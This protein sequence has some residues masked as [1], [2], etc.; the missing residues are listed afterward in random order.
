MSENQKKFRMGIIGAGIFAEANHYPSLSLHFFDGVERAAVCDL[1]KERADRIAEKYGW[2][3]TYDDLKKM[4]ES[5]Y[6]DGVI[7]C[8]GAKAS[9]DVTTQVLENGLPVFLEKPSSIDLEGTLKIAEVAKRKNLIVQVGH[10][11]RHG[12]A[13]RRAMEIVKDREK[14]GNIIQIESK[15]HGFPI[16]PT[17]YT[18]MLEWQCHNLDIVR[19]FAGDIKEI[20]AKSFKT[21]KKTGALTAMVRFDSGALGIFG[22]GTYG[23]PGQFSE[24]IEILGDKGR[25]VIITNA[26]EVTFYDEDVGEVWTSDWNPISKNQSHVFNG[27]VGELL[28][29]FE[30]VKNG[31]QPEPSIHDEVKTMSYLIEIAN[32]ADI[33]I[34]W[35]FISSAL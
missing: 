6:I 24:R 7:V 1:D 18:C 23:G 30:C 35:G 17:F 34:E 11:K 4:V 28:H 32:K 16:F 33:P 19:A 20:E 12:L 29:F 3:K 5:E 27:Y 14:F 10:Q 22:W 25:G 13:Y 26:R 21:G 8:V 9:V 2:K 31:R 15:M